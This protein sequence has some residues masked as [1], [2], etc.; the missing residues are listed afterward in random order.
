[1]V[2]SY[3]LVTDSTDGDSLI[4]HLP[5]HYKSPWGPTRRG[6]WRKVTLKHA[7]ASNPIAKS[8]VQIGLQFSARL[9][10]LMKQYCSKMSLSFWTLQVFRAEPGA[11]RCDWWLPLGPVL[12]LKSEV[13]AVTHGAL[14]STLHMHTL[15]LV[16]EV[17][18]IGKFMT[19][20]AYLLPTEWEK[21]IR[22]LSQVT[23]YK[24]HG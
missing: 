3:P 9:C 4:A 16:Q 13:L 15:M 10:Y 7:N 11:V 20:L 19:C 23:E 22:V 12:I 1:M 5:K 18:L 6:H 17:L 21:M 2:S 24:Q 8:R 14:V